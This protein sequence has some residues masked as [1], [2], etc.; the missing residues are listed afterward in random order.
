[1]LFSIHKRRQNQPLYVHSAGHISQYGLIILWILALLSYFLAEFC[2][3]FGGI[4][5]QQIYCTSKISLKDLS[6]YQM[7]Y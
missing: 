1:M 5:K 7:C 4:T 2:I 3:V 6:A